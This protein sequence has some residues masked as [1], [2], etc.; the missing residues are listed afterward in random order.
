M[1]EP[2][3]FLQRLPG[4]WGQFFTTAI[5]SIIGMIEAVDGDDRHLII[6]VYGHGNYR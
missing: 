4:G 5:I 6:I 1:W 3:A 2:M